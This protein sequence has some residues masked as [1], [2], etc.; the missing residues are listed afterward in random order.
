MGVTGT[1]VAKEAAEIILLDDNF[2]SIVKG[3]SWGR[4]VG[5]SVKKFLQF[6]LTVNVTAMVLTFVSAVASGTEESVLN[7][8]QLLWINLIMDTF[9]ALALATDPPSPS[10]LDRKPERKSAPLVTLGMAKMIVGQALLQ[11]VITFV[12]NFRGR[13]LLGYADT[14]G[15]VKR[16]KTLVFNTFVWLQICNELNN[17]RLDNKLNIF[18]GIWR[19][20]FFLVINLLMIGGQV[21]IIFFG[22]E[23]FKVTRLDGREWTLSA[24]LGAL[25]LPWGALIRLVP[26]VWI[27]ACLPP[28]LR[29]RWA[30]ETIDEEAGATTHKDEDDF[31]PPLR[32]YTFVRGQRVSTSYGGRGFRGYVREQKQRVLGKAQAARSSATEVL[33]PAGQAVSGRR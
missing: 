19:N 28:F 8:V 31:R 3:I 15:D 7:A 23:A 33:L 4:A 29:R 21:L 10:V 20:Y 13:Q 27:G 17:R 18:E 11:L 25:S 32:T 16:L 5:D 24:G 26:D 22:G 2:A 12:L 9:A 1:E 30:P 6:Q 14:E